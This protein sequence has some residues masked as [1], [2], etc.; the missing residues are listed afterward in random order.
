V[1]NATDEDRL[2]SLASSAA[3]LQERLSLARRLVAAALVGTVAGLMCWVML[4]SLGLGMDDFNNF[5]V[6]QA[7]ELVARRD[8]FA[9]FHGQPS[10]PLTAA[11]LAIPFILF[12][13]L[14][15]SSL[16]FGL[17]SA[18]LAFGLTRYGYLRL[19]VFLAYPFWAALLTVQWAPLIMAAALLPWLSPVCLA[20]PQIGMPI[21]LA[22]PSWKG[23][24]GGAVLVAVSFLLMPNWLP[25]WLGGIGSHTHFVP[26]LILPGPILLLSLWR[27][28]KDSHLLLLTSIAPQ[29]WFYDSFILWLIPRNR[30]EMIATAALSWGAG[31]S[32]YYH[33]PDNWEQAGLLA[34]WW[35]Y[36]PMLGILLVRR[37]GERGR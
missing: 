27:R 14:V 1:R 13:P 26:L 2:I 15:G 8:P 20:K 32:S 31:I 10:Y 22:Y 37:F 12:S 3:Q 16:F 6:Q 36:F 9:P 28:D 29:H 18:I 30:R 35:I 11:I 17:S 23:W 5:A 34:L 21:A 7:R 24:L 4:R 33:Q 19:F 25:R